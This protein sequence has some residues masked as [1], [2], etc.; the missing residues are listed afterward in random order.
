M[1]RD[2]F[3]IE[4]YLKQPWLT[5]SACGPFT[6]HCERIQN[7]I[8]L[9]NSKHLY[10]NEL[11]KVCFAHDVTHSDCADLAKRNISYTILKDRA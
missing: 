1:T 2:K 11:S 7:F 6:K 5:Y 8:E 9:G 3:M 4:L 10:R